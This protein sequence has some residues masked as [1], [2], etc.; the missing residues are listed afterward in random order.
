MEPERY[1]ILIVDDE[2]MARDLLTTIL[3]PKGHKCVTAAD[4]V[5]ALEKFDLE[6]FDVVITDIVMPNMDGLTLTR[7]IIKRKPDMPIMVITGFAEEHTA[8]DAIEAG[9]ADFISKPFYINEFSL[10]FQK[11]MRDRRIVSQIIE[12]EKEMEKI[13]NEMIAGMQHDAMEKI[14]ALKNEIAGLKKKL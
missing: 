2:A 12:R 5:D 4:G 6:D 14:A 1:K 7:E 9:A 10:R 13:G 3:S 8:E 11:M